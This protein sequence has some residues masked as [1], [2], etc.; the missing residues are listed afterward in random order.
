MKIKYTAHL[1]FRL[2]VREIPSLLPKEIFKKAQEHYYD[3]S[4][5]HYVVVHKIK[6]K[7]KI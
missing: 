5:G 6:F 1:K 3:S 4:T 2:K 7:D